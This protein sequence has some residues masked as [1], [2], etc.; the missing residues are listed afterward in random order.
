[1]SGTA[2]ATQSLEHVD[3]LIVGAGIS[4]IDTAYHL[5]SKQP[6]RTFAIVDA[7]DA[8]GGTWDLFRY[9]GIRSDADMQSFGLG[10]KPWTKDNAIADAHEILDY[11]REAIAENGLDERLHL[12]HKVLGANFSSDTAR[13]T[14]T[15][16]RTSDGGQFDVTCGVLFSAA[17]YYDYAGGY[18]PHFEGREDFRGPVVHPQQWPEDLD[19]A[20]KK[21]VVIGS[22]AT[23]VTLLPSM[24]GKAGHV[25]M[26]QR[27]PSYVLPVP[28]RDPIANTLRRL[29]PETVAYGISRRLNTKRQR[30]ILAAS[31]RYP[32]QMRRLI[33]KLNARALPAGYAVDTHFNPRYNPWD[34]R[35]CVVP[36]SDLFKAISSGAAS[37]VTDRITR[38]TEHGILLESSNELEADI[39]VTATGL[40][41]LP[42]GGIALHVD[43][44]AVDLHDHFIYK[45]MMVSD[46]PNFAFALGYTT[47]AWTLKVDLVADHLCR[48][49][50]HMDRHGYATVTPVA[51]DPS[52]TGRPFLDMD[53]AYINRAMH[54]FPQQGSHGP[55]TV[56]QDY[57]LDRA[58]LGTGPVEDPALRFTATKAVRTAA[59][60]AAAHREAAA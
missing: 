59:P 34:Q 1:M 36:D 17:G 11:L 50:A 19:Y 27:S 23:A 29:L 48:L 43:G 4:G 21:V 40:N 52:L 6:G 31:R 38:F 2:R 25:T 47:N 15:L 30:L 28:R 42:F 22:G 3:V 9:P 24:A 20:G 51:D 54:L 45:S 49:L 37:V 8:I 10:F 39:I 57:A 44:Q 55:W 56:S 26:L 7:R 60:D 12:G 46:V 14:V 32:R 41:M 33:R 18:T 13:W 5:K 35:L 16:E 58:R 53:T